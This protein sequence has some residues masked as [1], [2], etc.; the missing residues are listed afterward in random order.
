M[1]TTRNKTASVGY[2]LLLMVALL[3][4]SQ[5]KIYTA[6]KDILSLHHEELTSDEKGKPRLEYFNSIPIIHVYGSPYEMGFQY[7]SLLKSQLNSLSELARDLFS[8]KRLN[9]FSLR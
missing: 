3:L 7:G 4:F 6:Y 9:E 1:R 2:I 8:A 5:C